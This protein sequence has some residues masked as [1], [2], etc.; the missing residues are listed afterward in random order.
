[1]SVRVVVQQKCLPK[2]ALL[3]A[4]AI[5]ATSGVRA[6]AQETTIDRPLGLDLYMPVPNDNPLT[7][8]KVA[9]GRELFSETR[10]SRDG[11]T[12]CA[13]CHVPRRAFTDGRTV[14]SGAFGREGARNT[15]TLVNRGYGKSHFWD[16][17]AATLEEQV[18]MPIQG[19]QELDLYLEEAVARLR[20]IAAYDA[21]FRAN[22]GR[23]A[24]AEDLANALASYVRTIV[25]GDSPYDR[26]LMGDRDALSAAARRGLR[27]FRGR[28]N[29]TA[30]HL[31]PNLSDEKFHNTGVAFR[32]GQ[33]L[34]AGRAGL[35]GN[36]ADRGAFKT[37]TLRE[38]ERTGP[39]MHDGSLRSLEEVIEFYDR[40]GNP[41]PH[42]DPE[43]RPLG[44]AP[45]EKAALAEFLRS[46][47]G[48]IREGVAIAQRG[49]RRLRASGRG[50]RFST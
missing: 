25:A 33:F 3:I 9:L 50:V 23:G 39:Y 5:A 16:G 42:L 8:E 22:F 14:S 48:M 2:L 46:L 34:D 40:G 36:E 41:N 28:G 29:C 18:L 43:I 24:N 31:G 32:D 15:P 45:A 37:P 13:T 44:L 19:S 35:T 17:R 20:D 26:Y 38:I 7:P 6:T 4:V 10:L 11:K 47:D 1:M 27:V 12:A 49:L 21:R 30:C